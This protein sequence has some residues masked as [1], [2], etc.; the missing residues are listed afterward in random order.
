MKKLIDDPNAVASETLDGLALAYPKILRRVDGIQA[1]VRR[2]APVA[3]KVAVLTGGGSGHDPLFAGYVGRGLADGSVAG[4]IFA[5][6]LPADC[7]HR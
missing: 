7:P 2:D 6:P 4:N 1:V 3:G 5:S